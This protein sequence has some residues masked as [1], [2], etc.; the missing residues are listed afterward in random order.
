MNYLQKAWDHDIVD[1]TEKAFSAL[2]PR[3][4][5]RVGGAFVADANEGAKELSSN[6]LAFIDPPYSAVQYSRFYHVLET[7]AL[8]RCGAVTGVGRYPATELRPRSRYSLKTDSAKALDELLGTIASR[9]S[10]GILTF[11]EHDCSNGL[12]GELVRN[13]ALRYFHIYERH[14]ESK[15]STL[16]GTGDGR[17][18]EAGRAARLHAE[19][20]ILILRPK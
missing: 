3:F 2:A 16:G 10:F 12:S 18:N 20:L 13:I 11:P 7:I 8:G 14:I 15:F 4:A 1:C 6:N 5:K 17:A 19:E 9:R